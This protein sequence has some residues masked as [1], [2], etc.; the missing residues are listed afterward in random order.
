[1]PVA[2][3]DIVIRLSGGS[4]NTVAAA[5][6]GGAK[7]SQPAPAS[8]FD[9][10]SG[11]EASAGDVEYRCIYVHNA[12]ATNEMTNAVAWLNANTASASTDIAIGLGSSAIN[13]T[14]Q[15]VASEGAAPTGVTFS[16]AATKGAG[17]ALGNIPV[18]QH[19]AVWLRRTV[20]AGAAA[21][22]SDSA[23]IRV[24]CEAGA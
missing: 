5:S 1:M 4:S 19:R 18:G 15:T 10:V 3:A 22:A 2:S 6:L 9:S 14:E 11:A 21:A 7:S 24:E 16:A 20:T 23:T 13:G 12:S 17:I 8:L